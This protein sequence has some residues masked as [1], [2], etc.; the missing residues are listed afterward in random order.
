MVKS[1]RSGV[2]TANFEQASHTVHDSRRKFGLKGDLLLKILVGLFYITSTSCDWKE[3]MPRGTN[4]L[5]IALS[6]L[7]QLGH[8]DLEETCDWT[9]DET[10]F[11]RTTPSV[12]NRHGPIVDASNSTKG[13]MRF[14]NV[15]STKSNQLV[16]VSIVSI[17]IIY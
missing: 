9:W 13:K 11:K 16:F 14:L 12:R 1:T 5:Q 7:T 15:R 2:L 10:S 3:R 6:R 4:N 8:C 17:I